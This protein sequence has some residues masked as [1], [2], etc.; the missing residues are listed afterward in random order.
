MSS[1]KKAPVTFKQRVDAL[2]QLPRAAAMVWDVSAFGFV[3]LALLALGGAA[4]AVGLLY[5]SKLLVDAVVLAARSHQADLSPVWQWVVVE[6]ALAATATLMM[7]ASALARSRVGEKLAIKLNVV[8]LE[9]ALTLQLRHFEDSEFYDRLTRARREAGYRPLNVVTEGFG[10]LQNVLSFAGYLGALLALG[11]IMVGALMLAAIPGFLTEVKFSADAFRLRNW[12]SA[13]SRRMMYTEYVLGTDQHVKE[14]KLFGLGRFFLDQ[15]RTL[16]NAI[17]G[18]NWA[19]QLRRFGWGTILGLVA[20]TTYYACYAK[21][22]LDAAR[23]D[24]TLGDL[25]LYALAFRQGQAPFQSMLGALDGM[26]ENTLYLS[27]LNDFLATPVLPLPAALPPHAVTVESGAERGVRFDH[28]TFAYPGAPKPALEDVNL[29]IPAGQSLALVGHNGAGK[30]TFIKLL[31]GLYAP[32][33]GRVLLDGKN[34]L[35]LDEETLRARFAIIFQDYN[36]YQLSFKDN[37]AVGSLPHQQD[38]P[39]LARAVERGGADEVLK[40]LKEGQDTQLGRWF[41][42]GTELSGGQW[43]KVALSRAFMREE[44]DILVLDEPTAT[45]DPEAEYQVFE[46]FKELTKGRT[47]IV[48]SHRFATVRLADRIVVIQD[49]KVLEEGSHQELLDQDGRYA[50]MFRLQAQG[51]Q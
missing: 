12:Q 51:Y 3:L 10:L 43:Q 2:R 37:V 19:L 22:A 45:L 39:R 15:Y 8:I 7:R 40:T 16:A 4:N 32:T 6:G 34:V 5:V 27:N 35:E 31:T 20:T 28:V 42:K 24:I 18:E 17:F 48:I 26:Y 29:F 25:T 47:S 41:I 49:G 30:T 36:R 14:I 11:P 44:A 23:G 21:I 38:Q 9:K 13:D 1:D 33:A 50:H 46:R